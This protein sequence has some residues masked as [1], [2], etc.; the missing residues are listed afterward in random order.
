MTRLTM[1]GKE[2]SDRSGAGRTATIFRCGTATLA[3]GSVAVTT[4]H[5]T[6]NAAGATI[7]RSGAPGANDSS[8]VHIDSI[9][10]GTVTFKGYDTRRSKGKDSPTIHWWAV[11]ND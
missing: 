4:G 3:S 11:G 8:F 5:T 1:D 7:L 9:S 2:Q 10:D 6:V